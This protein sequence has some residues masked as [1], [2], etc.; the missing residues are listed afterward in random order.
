MLEYQ[1][2]KAFLLKDIPQIF[3]KKFLWLKKSKTHFHG[4]MFLMISMVKKLLEHFM[5]KELQKANQQG[6]RIEKAK[7][8]EK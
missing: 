2:K 1:N 3:L 5:K 8:K 7:K 4:H 6:F